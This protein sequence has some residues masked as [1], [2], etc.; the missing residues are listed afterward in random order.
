MSDIYRVQAIH[1][2]VNGLPRDSFVNTFHA[3]RTGG[4]VDRGDALDVAEAVRDFYTVNVTGET[5]AMM[6][7]FSDVVATT[8]HSVKVS[9][10]DEATGV[11][12]DGE[13]ADPVEE[14]AFD[15][16]GRADAGARTGY[17]SEVAVCISYRS[18]AEGGV[19][20][21]RRRGRIY[22]GPVFAAI[23]VEGT[24]QVPQIPSTFR[25]FCLQAA[26]DLFERLAGLG[27]TYRWC[28]YSRP[29]EGRA[30]GSVPGKP[31]LGAIAARP[32]ATYPITSFWMD[33]AFDTQRRRGERATT[34][35]TITA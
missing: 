15:H 13:G 11:N 2:H 32:G 18:G 14:L 23:G 5:E 24:S 30:A 22:F 6:D 26:D 10:I 7:Q 35:T 20:A 12:V 21:R 16:T 28:V 4:D 17:P 31:W 1:A 27:S 8:G 19:P 34:R 29:Y 33:N 25:D 3:Y 9:I